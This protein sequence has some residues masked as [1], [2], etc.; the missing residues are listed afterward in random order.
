MPDTELGKHPA[1]P[2]GTPEDQRSSAPNVED[3][4]S[5]TK[6]WLTSFLEILATTV[7]PAKWKTKRMLRRVPRSPK[8]GT[9][10]D[11]PAALDGALSPGAAPAF[12]AGSEEEAS[13]KKESS[14]TPSTSEGENNLEEVAN[15]P[16]NEDEAEVIRTAASLQQLSEKRKISTPE[17]RTTTTSAEQEPSDALSPSS[18]LQ[19][20]DDM[21]EVLSGFVEPCES[22][23]QKK[24]DFEI[25]AGKKFQKEEKEEGKTEQEGGGEKG[26]KEEDKL[27]D[28][29]DTDVEKENAKDGQWYE[30]EARNADEKLATMAK[31]KLGEQ[32]TSELEVDAFSFF[33]SLDQINTDLIAQLKALAAHAKCPTHAFRCEPLV[34]GQQESLE[35]GTSI[36]IEGQCLTQL[37][38][39]SAKCAH[40]TLARK[41][42]TDVKDPGLDDTDLDAKAEL[43]N[44]PPGLRDQVVQHSCENLLQGEKAVEEAF[45]T[46]NELKV[47]GTDAKE[48]GSLLSDAEREE[49]GNGLG[50]FIQDLPDD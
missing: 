9:P 48:K 29:A 50:E 38:D 19:F 49:V 39:W 12:G 8:S 37:S 33:E 18:F 3:N 45:T 13:A 31:S 46:S 22:L 5:Q 16:V 14:S 42:C 1:Q 23:L 30:Q 24:A 32:A 43:L 47:P 41:M 20:Y 40:E 35:L 17:V 34:K 2:A 21:S 6:T 15:N 10:E 26:E 4:A 36:K 27:S 25:A 28:F 44:L 11:V 7:N